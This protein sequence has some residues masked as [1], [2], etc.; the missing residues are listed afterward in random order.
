VVTGVGAQE[1]TVTRPRSYITLTL[2]H[3]VP[4]GQQA[5]RFI[6]AFVAHLAAVG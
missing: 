5:N 3:R 2:D 6:Q 4:D 1:R